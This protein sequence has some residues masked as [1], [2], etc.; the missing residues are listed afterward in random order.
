MHKV[1]VILVR[2]K[3]GKNFHLVD[4]FSVFL[5]FLSLKFLNFFQVKKSSFDDEFLPADAFVQSRVVQLDH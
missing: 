1:R 5:A 3:P 4:D 2:V